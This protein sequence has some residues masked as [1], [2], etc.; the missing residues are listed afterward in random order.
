MM[1]TNRPKGMSVT[2]M[3]PSKDGFLTENHGVV[4]KRENVIN[5]IKKKYMTM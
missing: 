3:K 5:K 1:M 2:V 4:T